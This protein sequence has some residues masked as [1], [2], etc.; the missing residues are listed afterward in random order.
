MAISFFDASGVAAAD[1]LFIPI[2]DLPGIT[3][4]ELASGEASNKRHSKVLFSLLYKLFGGYN[5]AHLGFYISKLKPSV[6]GDF[7]NQSF[8]VKTQ[9]VINAIS[10]NI[11]VIPVP[12]S[13][14]NDGIGD[15]SLTD[16]F[17][18]ASILDS[19][20]NTGGAGVLIPLADLA[21]HGGTATTLSTDDRKLL[22]ALISLI[23]FSNDFAVRSANPVVSSAIIAKA[24]SSIALV[25][26][27]ASAYAV[28]NPT[29][30]LLTA[31]KDRQLILQ[32]DYTFTLQL[33]LSALT[34]E[35]N[36]V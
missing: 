30:A 8:L 10:N 32:R 21:Q 22:F 33:S 9:L 4:T 17:V 34:T 3:S 13:G 1:G 20:D 28:T 19:A 26:L 12:V 18:G 5:T 15:F 11:D 35:I 23:T 31:N 14:D 16:Y 27:P 2:T 24:N 6:S 29:T 25:E 7:V 36:Y